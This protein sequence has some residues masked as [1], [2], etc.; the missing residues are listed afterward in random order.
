MRIVFILLFGFSYAIS[1]SS[2]ITGITASKISSFNARAIP[3]DVSEF[4][5][6]Y[7]VNHSSKMWDQDG[8]SQSLYSSPDSVSVSTTFGIRAAYA[9]TNTFEIGAFLTSNSS[10]WS[11][12]LNVVDKDRF[13]LALMAGLYLPFGNLVIDKRNRQASQVR[14]YGLGL[15]SSHDL[16]DVASID[17]NIQLQDYMASAPGLTDQDRFFSIDYGHYVHNSTILLIASFA[18]QHS[19]APGGNQTA[20][21]FNPGISFEMN[22]KFFIIA[23]GM[24]GLSGKNMQ[25]VNGFNVAWMISL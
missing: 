18:Y 14:S 6:N 12:K 16:S 2:Q 17:I 4:E 22:P 9:F 8:N 20:L 24:F 7:G 3:K 19:S 23:N 5:L 13:S 21:N 15:I 25:K 1:L 11:T 10:N